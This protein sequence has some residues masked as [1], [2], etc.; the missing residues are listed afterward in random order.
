MVQNLNIPMLSATR[1]TSPRL[2]DGETELEVAEP[3][4]AGAAHEIKIREHLAI[5]GVHGRQYVK[6]AC[7][8]VVLLD[9]EARGWRRASGLL[10]PRIG[11]ISNECDIY[12]DGNIAF[13]LC[14]MEQNHLIVCEVVNRL[15]GSAACERQGPWAP[16][17][18]QCG[19]R[20]R[21]PR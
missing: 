16:A 20:S 21:Q 3:F 11:S 9:D 18:H 6:L 4:F 17:G 10:S 5:R 12:L 1:R 2:D 14:K 15:K 7:D 8:K 13:T 19:P